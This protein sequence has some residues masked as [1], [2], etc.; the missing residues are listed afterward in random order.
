MKKLASYIP[1]T[2]S[3]QTVKQTEVIQEIVSPEVV[4]PVSSKYSH[5]VMDKEQRDWIQFSSE[6]RL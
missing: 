1:S 5:S 6:K 3:Q 2:S 4:L